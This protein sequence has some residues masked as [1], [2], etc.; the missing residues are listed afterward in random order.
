MMVSSSVNADLCIAWLFRLDSR[1]AASCSA[2]ASLLCFVVSLYCSVFW[3][4]SSYPR[5]SKEVSAD[6]LLIA[7]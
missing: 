6:R 2:S 4:E 5:F 1:M 7:G 3:Q